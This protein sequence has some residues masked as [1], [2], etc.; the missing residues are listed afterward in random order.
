M[1]PPNHRFALPSLVMGILSILG[2][3]S[4]ICPLFWV[5]FVQ[6]CPS[7]WALALGGG[8]LYTGNEA[9]REIDASGGTIGGREQ[10]SAGFI[11]GIIGVAFGVLAV[12]LGLLVVAGVLTM[13]DNPIQTP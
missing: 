1:T 3:L 9:R 5:P 10:A 2:A 4:C 8:A 11:M 6:L 7:L 12:C 13:P